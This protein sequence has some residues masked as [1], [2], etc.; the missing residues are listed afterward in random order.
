M[1]SDFFSHI[2]CAACGQTQAAEIMAAVCEH[3]GSA[4][5]D[6]RYKYD[7]VKAIWADGL[8][9]RETLLWRYAELLPLKD[10]D[11][12]ISMNEGYTPLFRLRPYERQYDHSPI[13]VKDERQGPTSSFKDRQAALAVT[14]LKQLGI[15]ECVLASTGN[16]GAAY[17]AYC[18]RAGINLWLFL[19]HLVPSEKMREAALYG[20]EVVKVDGTYDEAKTVAAEFARR[21]GIHFDRGARA[22][23]GKEAMKTLA[24]E[25][26]EQLALQQSED[27]TPWLAPDWY[28]Q[29]VS[30]GIGPLGVWKGF[31]ELYLMGL[32]D[33]IPKLGIIQAAGCAPMVEAFQ[34]GDKTATAVVPQTLIHV[35]A[36]GDPGYSYVMLEKAVRSNG[37]AMLAI[38]D[39]ETFAAMRR[40]ASTAGLSVEPAA[41]VAFAGLERMLYDGIIEEDECVVINCSGHTFPAESHVLGDQ[42]LVSLEATSTVA[43]R[44]LGLSE[45]LQTLDEQVTTVLIVDDNP[46]D[47]RLIRKLLK[48]KKNYRI[49]ETDDGK[50]ALNVAMEQSPNLIVTDLTMPAMDG[51]TLIEQL[52]WNTETRNIP[53]VVVSA[54]SLT[55]QDR[56][57]L[58]QYVQSIWTKGNFETRQLVQHLI[59]IVEGR[60]SESHLRR[61]PTNDHGF[62]DTLTPFTTALII[63]ADGAQSDKLKGVLRQAGQAMIFHAAT[64]REGLKLA[65]EHH[66][67]V[68][69]CAATL[70]DIAPTTILETLRK[71]PTL[72]QTAVILYAENVANE[73]LSQKL[74][75]L[76]ALYVES[77]QLK[78]DQI[79]LMISHALTLVG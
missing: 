8:G 53:I 36:T 65:Y 25:I 27:G 75:D 29:A 52:K 64:G 18:A 58:D 38:E 78:P 15:T 32:I 14:A 12:E 63:D 3:C 76:Q 46:N 28:I 55:E 61:H 13:F 37:G 34:R 68:I 20:A 23:P 35:L 26:A 19:T 54:K 30:G 56:I 60:T 7:A 69:L 2:E 11:P 67:D 48:A 73:E 51:L 5:L 49:F 40:V 74:K 21:K 44:N 17:A 39:G 59:H 71:E 66:P 1:I 9:K 10:R 42:Y 24:F 6:A 33:K 79:I 22:I 41:A 70:I 57:T 62:T 47:R 72:R 4:W 50:Q 31:Q 16:A 43:D 45:A 77:S